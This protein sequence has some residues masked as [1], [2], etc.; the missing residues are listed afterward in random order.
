M[1]W[2]VWGAALL[3]GVVGGV[4]IARS[5][6]SKG[7]THASASP[8]AVATWSAGTR[9]APAFALLDQHDKPVTLAGLHG[10]PAIVTFI[11]PLCRNFCPREASVLNQASAGLGANAPAIVAVSVD[12]WADSAQNFGEDAVHW[13]LPPGW[14]WGT[15]TYAQLARV[16][17]SYDVGVA[18]AKKTIAGVT[19]RNITH[20]GAAYLI[21]A[22]GYER[23]LFLYPFTSAQ[24]VDAAKSML[25]SAA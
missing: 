16:W 21:D 2:A 20:T 13:R 19:V 1:R 10:R 18:V 6:A 8:T 24:V 23:A 9:R 4:L 15:G 7:T 25:S 14:R 3:A 17:K 22:D 12:P 11:D 5:L